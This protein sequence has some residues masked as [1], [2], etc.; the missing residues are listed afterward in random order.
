MANAMDP[1]VDSDGDRLR[2]RTHATG[3]QQNVPEG[4]YGSHSS[5]M[6]NAMDPRV[7][8]D[9]DRYR[10]SHGHTGGQYGAGANL[11]GPAPNTAGPHKS[12]LLN[13]LDP[14]VD[15]KGGMTYSET[16]RRGL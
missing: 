1:R 13:K 7:D 4:T 10:S 16:Q 14:R 3:Y 15:S 12:D 9:A 5:R 8:S 2:K 6:G 11:P